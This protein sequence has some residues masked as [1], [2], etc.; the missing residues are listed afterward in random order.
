MSRAVAN[1]LQDELPLDSIKS[2]AVFPGRVTLYVREVAA[3][4]QVTE[5]HVINLIEGGRLHAVN[6]A[7]DIKGGTTKSGRTKAEFWRIP[8]ASYDAFI[9]ASRNDK[10]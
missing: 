3:K 5:Q 9:D 10:G 4:L 2:H 8:V 7:K 6:I 1:P